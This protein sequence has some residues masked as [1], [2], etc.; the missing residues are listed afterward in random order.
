VPCYEASFRIQRAYTSLCSYG[1]RLFVNNQ[2]EV[3]LLD[4][5]DRL[6]V[7]S[8]FYSAALLDLDSQSTENYEK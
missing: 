1:G 3:V 4:Y 5:F 2:F 7:P 6:V 8:M